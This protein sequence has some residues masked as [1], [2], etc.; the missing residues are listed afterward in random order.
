MRF[1]DLYGLSAMVTYQLT[2][3][4]YT[5]VRVFF[6]L[7]R[8]HLSHTIESKVRFNGMKHAIDLRVSKGNVAEFARRL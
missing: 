6:F 7:Q 4:I 1:I 2:L 8:A 3:P 5:L